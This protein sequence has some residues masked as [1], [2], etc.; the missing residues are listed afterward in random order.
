SSALLRSIQRGELDCLS[1]P[2]KPLDILAQQTVA[3]VGCEDWEE[4]KFF[5]LVRGAWP[6]R[7]VTRKEFD[8]VVQMLASGFST[9]RGRRAALIHYDGVNGKL[10]GRRGSRLLALT[11]GGAI[12]DNTDYR[13]VLEPSET[14]I[15]TVNEDFAIESLPGDIFQLGNASW[16]ILRVN[17]G[18]VRVEDAQGQPP[19]IPFWLGEAPGR[20]AELS[21][22]V[23]DLREEIERRMEGQRT[24][25]D[26]LAAET[27]LSETGA[28]QLADY[29]LATYK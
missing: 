2:E 8:D 20:T 13:V 5:E 19:S 12:P 3:A 23:S 4:Q 6:Y 22:A 18:Q 16:K 27:D 24:V 9:K 29:F 17:S 15:G 21:A 26:W 10:R 25:M 14:F 11:S 28:R 7:N 1:I